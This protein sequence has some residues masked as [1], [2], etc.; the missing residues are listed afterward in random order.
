MDF[1]GILMLRGK[2]KNVRFCRTIFGNF[3][4]F[5]LQFYKK[6]SMIKGKQALI[7]TNL[8]RRL[9]DQITNVIKKTGIR[10]PVFSIFGKVQKQK[11]FNKVCKN[12][13]KLKAFF[14]FRFLGIINTSN[15]RSKDLIQNYTTKQM[16]NLPKT[17]IKLEK[18]KK[19]SA[20]NP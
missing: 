8:Q 2:S 10:L 19:I 11:C 16:Q 12:L 1:L 6:Y 20:K 3:Y 17:V 5:M 14:F 15:L 13:F 4:D 9:K 7:N 18:S